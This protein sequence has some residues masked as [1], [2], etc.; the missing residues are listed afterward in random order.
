MEHR[1]AHWKLKLKSGVL[2]LTPSSCVGRRVPSFSKCMTD[3]NLNTDARHSGSISAGSV[4]T[5]AKYALKRVGVFG[6]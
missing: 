4:W 6:G 2:F 1:A 5:P 3:A